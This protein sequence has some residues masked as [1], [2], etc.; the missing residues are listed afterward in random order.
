[1]EK[2]VVCAGHLCIDITPAITNLQSDRIEDILKPGNLLDVGKAEISLGGSVSNTGLGMKKLGAD[3]TLM[4]K[5]GTDAFGDMVY[6]FYAQHGAAAGL[7]RDKEDATSY[8]VVLAVPGID[9]IFL[10]HAGANNTFSEADIPW[11][12]VKDAALFHFGYPTAMRSMYVQ[13]GK[14]LVSLMKKVQSYG[15]ATSLDLSSIDDRSEAGQQDW[16]RILQKVLPF[17]D[18]FVPSIEELCF[19]LDKP[20]YNALRERAQGQDV[21]NYITLAEIRSLADT[22]MEFGCKV[23]MIKCGA[24]GM[25]LRTADAKTLE[26]IS[27]RM[28]LDCQ[29]WGGQ[30]FFEKSYVPDRILSGT[31]AGDTSIAAFLTAV[32]KDCTPA[33]AMQYAAA[34]GASCITA[35]DALSGLLTFEELQQRIDNGWAKNTIGRIGADE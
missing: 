17:V 22:C 2:K 6:R 28:A 27:P 32:L 29:S 24:P 13:E 3:V 23:V 19:M 5:I 20:L 31:G 16:K 14:S 7:I 30:D 26:K 11:E 15:V 18:F 4:G 21:C 1:M 9:R 12:K 25:Y 10:H 34:T 8:S 35:Y 33:R